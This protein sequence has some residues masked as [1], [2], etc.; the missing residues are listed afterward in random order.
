MNLFTL[1]SLRPE[2]QNEITKRYTVA[3]APVVHLP[4][5]LGIST[6]RMSQ[7]PMVFGIE[8]QR[9]FRELTSGL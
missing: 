3:R 6:S 4:C 2:Y 7:S 8:M 5:Q 1:D 9:F